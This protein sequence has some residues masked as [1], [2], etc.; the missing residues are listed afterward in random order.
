M[1]QFLGGEGGEFFEFF[2]GG[3]GKSRFYQF[4][5]LT[6]H[7]LDILEP[8]P[9]C[10]FFEIYAHVNLAVEYYKGTIINGSMLEKKNYKF[11]NETT[12]C[13]DDCDCEWH[14]MFFTL[15]MVFIFLPSFNVFAYIYGR[16]YVFIIG[17]IM[18]LTGI[19]LGSILYLRSGQSLNIF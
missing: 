8:F 9:S 1:S 2:S 11:I 16:T 7:F 12:W 17:L 19:I 18:S 4:L 5:L 6:S 13:E 3:W 10:I 14:P 15:T